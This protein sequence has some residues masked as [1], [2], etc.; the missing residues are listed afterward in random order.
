M[1][2]RDVLTNRDLCALAVTNGLRALAEKMI[3][4]RWV[5]DEDGDPGIAMGR[6]PA[7]IVVSY[8]KW[9]DTF[10]IRRASNVQLREPAKR[11]LRV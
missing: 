7:R 3:R 10:I 9:P 4:P 2:I 11:E 1:R 5:V 6:G 8:Y